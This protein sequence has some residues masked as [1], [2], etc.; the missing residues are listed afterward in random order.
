MNLVP[1][2]YLEGPR[3]DETLGS[4]I[5]RAL[6]RAPIRSKLLVGHLLFGK[7]GSR[8]H[9]DLP[10]SVGAV[11]KTI[12]KRLG[13]TADELIEKTTI[14][15]L[16]RPFL[17]LAKLHSVEAAMK[18]GGT[19]SPSLLLT[20]HR[21]RMIAPRAY[22][23]CEKCADEDLRRYG[24]SWWRRIHQVRGV[25]CCPVHKQP[26]AITQF[27]LGRGRRW[28][29]EY[30]LVEDAEIV[31]H[32]N[33]PDALA[34]HVAKQAEY[35]LLHHVNA[36]GSQRLRDVY[37]EA[38]RQKGFVENNRLARSD[39]LQEFSA[40]L[41]MRLNHSAHSFNAAN[42]YA[43]PARIVLGQ[44]NQHRPI[45]H[46]Y[47]MYFLDLTVQDVVA[48]A[49]DVSQPQYQPSSRTPDKCK[50]RLLKVLWPN[51]SVS[52]NAIA[53]TFGVGSP[54]V[55]RWAT[56]NRLP[57]P[58]NCCAD[59]R[60]WFA[61]HRATL[62][63]EWLKIRCQGEQKHRARVRSWLSTNDAA[64]FKRNET[65]PTANRKPG[66]D[67]QVRDIEIAS[68]MP[69]LAAR[70]RAKYPPR[71]IS[72]SSLCMLFSNGNALLYTPERLPFSR[73]AAIA[74]LETHR[75]FVLRKIATLR[76]KHPAISAGYIRNMAS[77]PREFTDK[78]MLDA[79]GYRT[80][81]GQLHRSPRKY[82]RSRKR[83]RAG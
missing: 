41:G 1:F 50:I 27:V 20:L 44:G 21:E 83:Q 82:V 77:V 64:W 40:K 28:S 45:R 3:T 43:W 65:P 12:G 15:P 60:A 68:R 46:F 8:L 71:R 24:F 70:I 58:R 54:T 22:R 81:R 14:L 38:L 19:A 4:M 76:K 72:L 61:K 34:I 59:K 23:F 74:E 39:L 63:Q 79:M 32:E 25:E 66:V 26:L 30:P 80:F 17:P 78:E 36:I 29:P 53:R 75:E 11:A 33:P 31:A 16:M 56:T 49:Q 48:R 18:Y 51:C 6:D 9:L 73:K 42:P 37:M 7:Y 13:L 62:R 69:A 10:K 47:M 2:S 67:W 57:F 55:V 35:L 52:I 5:G